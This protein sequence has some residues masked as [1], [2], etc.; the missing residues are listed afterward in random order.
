[1]KPGVKIIIAGVVLMI[2]GAVCV[3]LGIVLKLILGQSDVVQFEVPG[4]LQTVVDEPGRY[5]LWNDHQ[6]IFEGKSY[7]RA[8]EIPDGFEVSVFGPNGVELAF[9]SDLNTSFTSGSGVK[10]SFGY[11]DVENSGPVRVEIIGDI[12]GRIFSFSQ[13]SLR[14]MFGIFVLG[15][16]I[17]AL[18][19]LSGLALL[20]C[21]IVK[22]ANSPKPEPG[23]IKS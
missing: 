16:I 5:Y 17:A 8:I 19:G 11:V 9:S 2:V 21:G 23:G 22:L 6:T 1:M 3:P 15:F 4:L 20:I 18:F 14:G 13:F 10:Q 12:E 7:N